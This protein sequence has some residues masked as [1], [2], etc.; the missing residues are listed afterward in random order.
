MFPETQRPSAPSGGAKLLLVIV[1]VVLAV[2]AIPASAAM[3][4]QE[5]G[6][7]V[8]ALLIFLWPALAFYAWA[9]RRGDL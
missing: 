8:L 5:I 1:L 4:W 9:R 7:I 3:G 6:L 2:I